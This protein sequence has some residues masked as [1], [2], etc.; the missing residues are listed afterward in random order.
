MY[1]LF[2]GDERAKGRRV[3]EKKALIFLEKSAK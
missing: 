3:V 1:L 2:C